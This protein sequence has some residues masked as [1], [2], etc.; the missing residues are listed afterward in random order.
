MTFKIP[1]WMKTAIGAGIITVGVG[2]A[3]KLHSED[4]ANELAFVGAPMCEITDKDARFETLVKNMGLNESDGITKIRVYDNNGN[5]E[6]D[7]KD[8]FEAYIGNER[9]PQRFMLPEA[10]KIVKDYITNG[11]KAIEVQKPVETKVSDSEAAEETGHFY[12]DFND[13]FKDIIDASTSPTNP[14]TAV[15]SA[16]ILDILE[17]QEVAAL[18]NTSTTVSKSYITITKDN[19]KFDT[20]LAGFGITVPAT[21][22][23]VR[24]KNNNGALNLGDRLLVSNGDVLIADRTVEEMDMAYLIRELN[25]GQKY[26][27][28]R[29]K[30]ETVVRTADGGL[31]V[32]VKDTAAKKTEGETDSVK[33]ANNFDTDNVDTSSVKKAETEYSQEAFNKAVK[34]I[35]KGADVNGNWTFDNSENA[36]NNIISADGTILTAYGNANLGIAGYVKQRLAEMTSKINLSVGVNPE[37]EIKGNTIGLDLET[38]LGIDQRQI[39]DSIFAGKAYVEGKEF[40][41]YFNVSRL[42][43]DD[44]SS[45]SSATTLT[46]P[47]RIENGVLTYGNEKITINDRKSVFRNGTG[48]EFKVSYNVD[49]SNGRIYVNFERLNEQTESVS[50]VSNLIENHFNS[51]IKEYGYTLENFEGVVDVENRTTTTIENNLTDRLGID[52]R[53]KENTAILTSKVDVDAEYGDRNVGQI[54]LMFGSLANKYEWNV[55]TVI[56]AKISEENTVKI[57]SEQQTDIRYLNMPAN[58]TSISTTTDTESNSTTERPEITN[59]MIS[60]GYGGVALYSPGII[61]SRRVVLPQKLDILKV[62]DISMMATADIFDVWGDLETGRWHNERFVI[63]VT[64]EPGYGLIANKNL[65][66]LNATVEAQGGNVA[67][68]Y[69]IIGF[70]LAAGTYNMPADEFLAAMRESNIQNERIQKR[71]V[72]NKQ[73]TQT[74]LR[75]S[76]VGLIELIGKYSKAGFDVALLPSLSLEAGA[77]GIKTWGGAQAIGTINIDQNL[78]AFGSAEYMHNNRQDIYVNV[79]G[80]LNIVDKDLTLLVYGTKENGVTTAGVAGILRLK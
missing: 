58:D 66:I 14:D 75:N 12:T 7:T 59:R 24:D 36:N 13:V 47:E 65:N 52:V 4:F 73:L 68:G 32:V 71:L 40:E 18:T 38:L 57:R 67:G 79:I 22:I 21:K 54:R 20:I 15:I 9:L 72:T 1:T 46:F 25:D 6:F 5:G 49:K 31:G 26:V 45:K 11:P 61:Y 76:K 55:D 62:K 28:L 17:A 34:T 60:S 30:T 42:F 39:K 3:D 10:I 43:G 37:T 33:S 27:N 78:K 56:K 48:F 74:D 63:G 41:V 35:I 44:G 80:G 16:N 64:S 8:N 70:G 51:E 2:T 77:H 29:G 50:T 69:G 19:A 23:E 53:V